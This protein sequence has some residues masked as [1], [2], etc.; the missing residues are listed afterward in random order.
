MTRAQDAKEFVDNCVD[1]CERMTTFKHGT[2]YMPLFRDGKW[3]DVPLHEILDEF[4]A[5]R[6]RTLMEEGTRFIVTGGPVVMAE[7]FDAMKARAV[8]A[9]SEVTKLKEQKIEVLRC[10]DCGKIVITLDD[11]RVAT[12][13]LEGHGSGKCSGKWR[14][15]GA[16]Q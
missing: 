13:G 4:A 8:A 7:K 15:I 12:G 9:G 3:V 2:V 14:V 6:N 16:A 10:A 5:A 11:N 1:D